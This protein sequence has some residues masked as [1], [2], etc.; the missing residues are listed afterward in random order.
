MKLLGL[1]V[2]LLSTTLHADELR[3]H[4]LHSPLGVNWAT[5]WTLATSALKN[6]IAPV[7]KKRAYSISHVFVELKC[8]S[9]K[10]HIFRG[11]T[12]APGTE[13]RDLVFKKKYGLGTLFHTYKG[14]LEKDE[15]IRKDL[16]PY[17]GHKR[18]SELA[19]KV[20]PE[21]C[22]RMVNYVNE[23]ET[24]GYGS[25]YSGLQ[26]DP[27]KREGSGCSAFGVSFMRVAGLM[28]HFTEE[29]KENIDIPTRFIGG[30]MTGKKVS[31]LYVLTHPGARWNNKEKHVHLTAWNPERM[32]DW[33]KKTY[34]HVRNG[35]YE[36]K[37]PA[38]I[39]RKGNTYKVE[40]DMSDRPVPTGP[41]WI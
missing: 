3:L 39:D 30:P 4:F 33:V 27:L 2:L 10:T 28:D 26:A 20:S 15:S 24:L 22:E 25:M 37:W 36:G 35:T 7:G 9:T 17:D 34:Q 31:I 38:N 13:D 14:V 40:L 41:F 5:P 6:Q 12:S 11:M 8:D 23:Y 16:A 18:H 32:H 21:A 29:W 19:I 1:L